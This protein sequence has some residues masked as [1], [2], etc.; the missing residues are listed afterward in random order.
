[1]SILIVGQ[2]KT[3]EEY[4]VTVTCTVTVLIYNEVVSSVYYKKVIM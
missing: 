4:S 2:N 3:Y 1:M